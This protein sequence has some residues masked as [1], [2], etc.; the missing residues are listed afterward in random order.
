MKDDSN[1]RLNDFRVIAD[2]LEEVHQ[3]AALER[4]VDELI[5]GEDIEKFVLGVCFRLICHGCG[6]RSREYEYLL[7]RTDQ[8]FANSESTRRKGSWRG[9][10]RMEL[11][12][13]YIDI[14]EARY[15]T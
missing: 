15:D 3:V 7:D 1:D 9:G 13:V 11:D 6:N 8:G 10:R 2:Q 4:F 12:T 5:V 14:R